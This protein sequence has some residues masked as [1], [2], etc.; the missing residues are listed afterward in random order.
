MVENASPSTVFHL[1]T[2]ATTIPPPPLVSTPQSSQAPLSSAIC[3]P[4]PVPGLR[5]LSSHAQLHPPSSAAHHRHFLFGASCRRDG[6][7]LNGRSGKCLRMS[8]IHT[9]ALTAMV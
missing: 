3:P 7:S 8:Y 6:R 9:G 4:A 1:A 2:S 5:P